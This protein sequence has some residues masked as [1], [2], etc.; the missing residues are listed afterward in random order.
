MPPV[1][2]A[3][4]TAEAPPLCAL[5]VSGG[6]RGL[7]RAIVC[8][9]AALGH[10]VAFTYHRGEQQ[11]LALTEELSDAKGAVQ[12]FAMDQ[13]DDHSV[14]AAVQQALAWRD[15]GAVVCNAGITDRGL[16]VTQSASSW[17]HV[18]NVNLGG[19]FR[20]SH[21]FLM[22]FMGRRQGAFVHIGSV[23]AHGMSGQAAYAASKAGLIGL[24]GTLAREYG[25]RGIRS[26]VISAGLFDQGLSESAASE[27]LQK[28][29]LQQCP[30]RRMGQADDLTQLV[31][32]LI[33]PAAA[34]LNGQ[35][36][37]LTGGLNWAP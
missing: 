36:I 27:A 12:A 33:S 14:T 6:A 15:I 20:L 25:P 9:A 24:S 2:L 26:N 5:F 30:S 18:L 22:H 23:A 11:A 21:A 37:P 35:D 1:S 13:S 7:G 8:A 10:D 32:Y 4:P 19:A 34:F 29:W 3:T 28:F 16:L 17:Q 31:L